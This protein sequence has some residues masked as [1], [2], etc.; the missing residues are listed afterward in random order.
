MLSVKTKCIWI[1]QYP[2]RDLIRIAAKKNNFDY[3][4]YFENLNASAH[5]GNIDA[6]LVQ[7]LMFNYK[8]SRL[9]SS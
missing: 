1:C 8:K 6:C 5:E 2:E 9:F 4:E 7:F 3:F